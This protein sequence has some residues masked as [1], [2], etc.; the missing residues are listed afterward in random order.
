MKIVIV[1]GGSLEWTPKI[2]TDLALTPQVNGSTIVLQDIEPKAALLQKQLAQLICREAGVELTIEAINNQQ[3]ALADA[4][5]VI[6][7]IAVGGLEAHRV[8]LEVPAKYGMRQPVGVNVGPGGINR[9]LR[10]IPDT[11][12]LC[13]KMEEVCPNATL[14]NLTNPMTQ[15]TWA[16][17]RETSIQTIGLCHEIDHFRTHL[18]QEIFDCSTE[19]IW[20]QVGGINHLPWISKMRVRGEDGFVKLRHWLAEHGP[21]KF[22]NEGLDNTPDSVF[23]DRHAAKFK[24]FLAV[25]MLPGAGDRH[26]VEF[27]PHFVRRERK[28]GLDYGVELTTIEQRYARKKVWKAGFEQDLARGKY[29]KIH[30]SAEQTSRIIAALSGGPAGRFVVNIPNEG[31][32][33]N[34]PHGAVVECTAVIDQFGIHPEFFGDLPPQAHAV[35]AWHLEEMAL[36]LDAAIEGDRNKALQALRMDPVVTDWE[37]AEKVLDEMIADTIEYLPQFR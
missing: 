1:G 36:T 7:Q 22:A 12:A 10:H 37:I 35:T 17:C 8:D 16:A 27:F 4:D 21:D 26:V 20:V 24:I 13:R 2:I 6:Y 25:G 3:E 33:S 15:L 29:G 34:L 19:D 18:S 23:R 32:I 11:I 9:A 28:F 5:F 30:R 14:I 31:Q